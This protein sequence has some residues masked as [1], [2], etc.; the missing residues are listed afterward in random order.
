MGPFPQPTAMLP[1]LPDITFNVKFPTL[2]VS[3]LEVTT[4]GVILHINKPAGFQE[5]Q[6]H[7]FETVMLTMKMDRSGK[8]QSFN[9]W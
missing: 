6:K 4:A 1:V 3:L 7:L 8:M 2:Q 9:E 5:G